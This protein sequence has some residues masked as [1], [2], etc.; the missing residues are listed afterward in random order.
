M[1]I[2]IHSCIWRNRFSFQER[3]VIRFA[4]AVPPEAPTGGG[5]DAEKA[6]E[7]KK[8]DILDQ[9]EM[10]FYFENRTD[11]KPAD[12]S[13]Y[14]ANKERNAPPLNAYEQKLKAAIAVMNGSP[15]LAKRAEASVL[16]Q[17]LCDDLN[18]HSRFVAE[19][20]NLIGSVEVTND[21]IPSLPR[22]AYE[23]GKNT[24]TGAWKALEKADG[25]DRTLML[26][27]VA[28][29]LGA[30]Y[31]AWSWLK[32]TKAGGKIK[33]FGKFMA[34]LGLGYVAF[35]GV[36]KVVEH[37]SG[38]PILSYKWPDLTPTQYL[39]KDA[40][41]WDKDKMSFEIRETSEQMIKN[42]ISED[43]IKEIG[44]G[45]KGVI[46]VAAVCQMRVSEFLDVYKNSRGSR[47]IERLHRS[48]EDGLT[49]EERFAIIDDIAKTVGLV[50]PGGNVNSIPQYMLE[51]GM[52]TL[53]ADYKNN[54]LLKR[55]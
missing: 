27:G 34:F 6:E 29:A 51:R 24:L 54:P 7:A 12:V 49:P 55:D 23:V 37:T 41:A 2:N 50:G 14:I 43:F 10:R 25:Y 44:D 21:A 17:Q 31:L 3:R 26:A 4:G 28:G 42:G 53:M 15:D 13:Q 40:A 39:T 30:T 20:K 9:K 46:P 11:V 18:A 48:K 1:H 5:S 16:V 36:N 32:G 8:K 52:F 38:K 35:E 22:T 45:N 33:S 47:K 19:R